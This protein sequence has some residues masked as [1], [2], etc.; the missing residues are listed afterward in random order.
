MR[1]EKQLLLDEVKGQIEEYEDFA[2]FQYKGISANAIAGFRTNIAKLGGEVQM[3]RKRILLKAA[4]AAGFELDL[5]QLPGH[6]GLVY[7]G[8]DPVEMTKALFQFSKESDTNLSVL[9]GRLDGKMYNGEQV[10]ALSKLPGKDA[11]RA[12]LLGLLVAPLSQTVAVI[13][14]LL[15]AVP[16]CLENKSKKES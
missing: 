11:M 8:E 15:A 1:E 12:E 3:I 13:N 9:G 16:C 10:E 14:A 5:S 2:L 4:L 7:A 6:I